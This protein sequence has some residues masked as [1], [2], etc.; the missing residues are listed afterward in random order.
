MSV[1]LLI[2]LWEEALLLA[3]TVANTLCVKLTLVLSLIILRVWCCRIL[4]VL[5]KYLFFILHS[6]QTA[7]VLSVSTTA[8][9]LATEL[10]PDTTT[11]NPCLVHSAVS[12]A[13]LLVVR[14]ARASD[15]FISSGYPLFYIYFLTEVNHVNRDALREFRIGVIM[16]EYIA[17]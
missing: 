16:S 11:T 12:G 2:S 14:A 6:L 4:V 5:T 17:I 1:A 3:N 8:V 10:K 7:N 9:A 15:L 13:T